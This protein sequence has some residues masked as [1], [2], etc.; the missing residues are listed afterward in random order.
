M[1]GRTGRS[2]STREAVV[3]QMLGEMA[4]RLEKNRPDQPITA[5]GRIALIQATTMDPILSAALRRQ[6]P[7]ITGSVVRREYA[8]QLRE[9][10]GVA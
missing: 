8:A 2:A 10:A 6:V 4:D 5:I 7:E 3:R 9:I 1:S